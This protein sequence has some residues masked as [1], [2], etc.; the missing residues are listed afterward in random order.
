MSR[1]VISAVIALGVLFLVYGLVREVSNR[2]PVRGSTDAMTIVESGAGKDAIPS[3]DN[4]NFT[5][6]NTADYYLSDDGFGLDVNLGGEHRFYPYQILVWH[7]IVNAVQGG[8]AIAVTYDPLCGSG[9]VYE[10]EVAGTTYD[11]GTSGKL[12]NNNVLMYDRQTNSLWSQ[13]LGTAVD[14]QL[15]DA[16]LARLTSSTM[17]WSDWKAAYPGG[18]VLSRSTGAIR[19]YTSNP[20]GDYAN[21]LDVYFP[22]STMDNSRP[23]KEVVTGPLGETAYWFCWAALRTGET[24]I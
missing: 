15:K 5:S 18:L 3:I 13:I 10:R 14:G 11:F 9:A 24:P 7:E 2:A 4:P 12:W 22:L 19:D 1:S 8:T 16:R 20:Y 21:N 23:I 6:A 17:L